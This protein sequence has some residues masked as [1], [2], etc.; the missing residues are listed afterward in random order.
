[1]PTSSPSTPPSPS[2]STISASAVALR[3]G[4]RDLLSPATGVFAWGL[5]TGVAMAKSSLTLTQCLI[6]TLIAYAG[7][8]QLAVLPLIAAGAP[9]WLMLVTATIVNLR[10]VVYVAALRDLFEPRPPWQRALLGFLVGD[11]TFVVYSTRMLRDPAPSD[12][13]AYYFGAALCN[14]T[15]WQVGSLIGIFAA[16]W[17]PAS[18]GLELAGSLAL[19]ALL[20]PL[21]AQ[22]PAL[23]GIVVAS[24]VAVLAHALPLKLGILCGALAGIAIA[25]LIDSR[26]RKV[27]TARS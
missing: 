9:F 4:A 25:M 1:M 8:A 20:V 17:I 24:I 18:W 19:I 7:S 6:M 15:F 23:A 27:S 21:F 13:V 26:L 2:A 14:W 5:V 3:E 22:R 12:R 11:I 10:F 16:A